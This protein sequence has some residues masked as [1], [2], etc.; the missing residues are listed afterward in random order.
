M[1]RKSFA[2]AG[3]LDYDLIAGIGKPVNSA[4]A[5]DRVVEGD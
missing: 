2:I 1:G 3:T 4:V 5:E